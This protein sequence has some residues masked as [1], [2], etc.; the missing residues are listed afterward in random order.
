MLNRLVDLSPFHE[1][2]VITEFSVFNY[3]LHAM[4]FAFCVLLEYSSQYCIS[5]SMQIGAINSINI[6]LPN[7]HELLF[8]SFA[9]H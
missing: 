4:F 1:L 6:T 7:Q 2:Y 9:I 3:L 8:L 5:K